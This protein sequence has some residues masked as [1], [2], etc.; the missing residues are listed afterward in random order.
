MKE[1]LSYGSVNI[2]REVIAI[3]A[4]IA[5]QEIEGVA[6][7]GESIASFVKLVSG[8]PIGRGLKVEL[9][10]KDIYIKIPV[11]VKQNV[12]FP[13][14][15]RDIQTHVKEVVESMTGL[16][17]REVNVIIKGVILGKKREEEK[18]K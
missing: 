18:I 14:I 1:E 7:V 16:S 15:A 2:S 4:G 13:D 10:D 8:I 3:I 6:Q 9:I 11:Y 17:V 5:A 12:F